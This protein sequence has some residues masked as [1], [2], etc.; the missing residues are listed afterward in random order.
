[1]VALGLAV[2]SWSGAPIEL[3]YGLLLLGGAGRAFSMPAGNALLVQLLRSSQFASANAWVVLTTQ[4]A[5]IAG[6]AAGGLLIAWT[7]AAAPAY[8]AALVG[9]LL[10]VG[11]L[12]RLPAVPRPAVPAAPEPGGLFAGVV[13]I[14]RSPVFLAAITLDLVAV[15][16]GGAVA[17]L[18]LF[19][20]DILGVGPAGL[21]L[22]R[23][24]PSLGAVAAAFVTTRFATSQRPGLTLLL[25]VVGFGIA[26][27]G[28]G[29]SRD[30]GL[31]LVCLFLTGA[32]N[33]ISV[34]IR[35]T[36]QQ[37]ITPDRLQGRI[38]AISS[39]FTG[40]SNEL[41][42]FESGA[43]AALFGPVISVVGGGLGTIVAVPLV[44]LAWPAL[45]RIGPLHTLK[46]SETTTA[47]AAE[48]TANPEPRPA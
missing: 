7:G 20:R 25:T 42:A 38:A 43:V 34:V 10:A 21:G 22:L 14:K 11:T 29:L 12:A 30:L 5:L 47:Q 8:L 32:F 9:Q 1:L 26:T 17:L 39:L 24:A 19:A 36:L 46:P 13:F 31:S 45:A 4:L 2:V 40:L 16:L 18:P 6:P 23:S 37:V 28:F 15:L 3:I 41:G 48:P 33:T 44:A 27:V 35:R